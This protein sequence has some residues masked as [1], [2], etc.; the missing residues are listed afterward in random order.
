MFRFGVLKEIIYKKSVIRLILSVA[1]AQISG[2]LSSLEYLLRSCV[3][4]QLVFCVQQHPRMNC[5]CVLRVGVF[6]F[7]FLVKLHILTTAH[8]DSTVSEEFLSILLCAHREL[9]PLSF[10]SKSKG[11]ERTCI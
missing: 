5:V 10:Q 4:E 11:G 3:V 2:L 6:F 8:S 9:F 1:A 7:S